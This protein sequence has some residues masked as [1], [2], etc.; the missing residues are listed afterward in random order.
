MENGVHKI[1]GVV[2][3]VECEKLISNIWFAERLK[4]SGAETIVGMVGFGRRSTDLEDSACIRRKVL[5]MFVL[6]RV[7]LS[8]GA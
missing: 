4:V 1:R 8:F 3:I 7:D 6:N 2:L 5:A